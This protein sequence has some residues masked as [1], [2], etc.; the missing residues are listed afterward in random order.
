[1]P[2]SIT[3]A[4]DVICS[5]AVPVG[6]RLHWYTDSRPLW[7]GETGSPVLWTGCAARTAN[8]KKTGQSLLTAQTHT[9][10]VHLL[11]EHWAY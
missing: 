9:P 6:T 7:V 4:M 1:M 8:Q 3:A 11:V 5:T 10:V 2:V